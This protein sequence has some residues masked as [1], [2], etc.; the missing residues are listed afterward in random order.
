MK[1]KVSKK[2]LKESIRAAVTR[3][4]NEAI[5]AKAINEGW[6]DDDD[7][8]DEFADVLAKNGYGRKV[9]GK[10]QGENSKNK[11]KRKDPKAAE[12]KKAAMADIKKETDS[13]K[14]D[15]DA[16]ERREKADAAKNED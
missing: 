15:E 16:I 9:N 5:Q 3:C 12:A 14:R 6:Y 7:D 10:W 13:E 4:L 8:D 11:Y 2:Q 1:I